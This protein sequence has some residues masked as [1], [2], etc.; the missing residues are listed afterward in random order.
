[1][2]ET[3]AETQAGVP[4]EAQKETQAGMTMEIPSE[5]FSKVLFSGVGMTLDASLTRGAGIRLM[6]EREQ[7]LE[8][9]LEK[10]AVT[11]FTY[12]IE[13]DTLYFQRVLSDRTREE[14]KVRNFHAVL[15]MAAHGK[16]PE[17]RRMAEAMREAIRGPK[18]DTVEFYGSLFYD[19]PHW[20]RVEYRSVPAADG[21]VACIVGFSRVVD[22]EHHGETTL[23]SASPS[24]TSNARAPRGAEIETDI[25]RR[26]RSLQ[27]GEK[28]TVFLIELPNY[29][30]LLQNHP[31]ANAGGFLR[32]VTES[33]LSDFRGEDILG[34]V[35][36][37]VFVLFICGRTSLDIIERRAQRVIELVQK[38]SMHGFEDIRVSVGVAATGTAGSLYTTLYHRAEAAL[39]TAKAH[40]ENNYRVYFE[41]EKI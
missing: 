20:N 29:H 23:A 27:T 24:Y 40:G 19:R 37:N 2:A 6:Q 35:A 14:R 3:A 38:V 31:M 21:I 41:E 26:L 18:E 8:M 16:E 9:M 22:A 34:Q 13:E 5:G 36:E 11:I 33:I 15:D 32:A 17:G 25:N 4:A 28:G 30:D 39:A 12:D 1:M 7:A 10:T